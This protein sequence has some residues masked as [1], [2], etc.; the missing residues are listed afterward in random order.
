MPTEP[1][2]EPGPSRPAVRR[3]DLLVPLPKQGTAFPVDFAKALGSEA[4]TALADRFHEP[5][6]ASLWW[7]VRLPM[8]VR[9]LLDERKRDASYY[10]EDIADAKT[11]CT[12]KCKAHDD[13]L[14]AAY[15]ALDVACTL[16][17]SC[18]EAS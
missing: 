6:E 1:A 2:S 11:E 15:D 18:C 10:A 4:A 9:M 5:A 17:T 14:K 3:P 12:R 13:E 8:F 16:T 7:D